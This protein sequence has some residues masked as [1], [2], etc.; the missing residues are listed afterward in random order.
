MS[1][2]VE[3][4]R[5]LF[6][7]S[8]GTSVALAAL[9]AVRGEVAWSTVTA[10]LALALALGLLVQ[11]RKPTASKALLAVAVLNLLLVVPE[12]GLRV[13]G[14]RFTSGVQ[15]GYPTPEDFQEFAP[16]PD[17]FWTLPPEDPLVNSLG[18]FGPEPVRPKPADAYRVLFFGD[19][20]LQQG[21]PASV[22][23]VVA[24]LAN[25]AR[26]DSGEP[27]APRFEAINLAMSGYSSHQGLRAVQRYADELEPD[28]VVAYYGWNDHWRA[29]GAVDRDKHIDLE[30]ERVFRASR[31][32]QALRRAALGLAAAPAPLA[33]NR[34]PIDQYRENLTALASRCSRRG[35]PLVLITA[36]SAHRERGVPEYL[37]RRGFAPD[38]ATVLR[39]HD[40]Y[41][42]VVRQVARDT[43]AV[44]CDLAAELAADFA[45]GADARLVFVEDGIHFNEPGRWD[46]AGRLLA[47]LASAGLTG[48]GVR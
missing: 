26:L 29:Y 33:D 12:L 37:V 25:Q 18:F 13:G 8:V 24:H 47:C 10:P 22:P 43:D 3:P 11:Q 15:F 45:A 28:A 20:C 40:A 9:L 32:A 48:E 16:D 14:F 23:E 2:R 46:V 34:V 6:A 41:N 36:P 39:E 27:R 35:V 21:Q 44:L 17:L 38:D 31:L 4:A 5:S 7:A 30:R 42:E 19:S 1:E